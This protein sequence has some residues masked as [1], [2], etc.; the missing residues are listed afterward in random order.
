MYF[1]SYITRI[2]YNAAL[3]K[4]IV[5]LNV[6][7][8]TASI[9]VTGCFITYGIGQILSGLIGDKYKPNYVILAGI[10]GSSVINFAMVFMPNIALINAVWCIN[11]FFQALF[12]PPLVRIMTEYIPEEKY[13]VSVLRVSQS[14]YFAT[15]L[16]YALVP[17]IITFASWRFVFVFSS[18]S[19]FLFAALWYFCTKDMTF[20]ATAKSSQPQNETKLDIKFLLAVGFI[21]MFL[22]IILQGMLREGVSTWMPTYV[23]EVFNLGSSVSILTGVILPVF[24]IIGASV[25]NKIGEKINNE[26]KSATLFFTVAFSFNVILAVFF[27]KFAVLDVVSMAVIN[28]CMHGINIMLICDAPRHFAKYGKVSTVSGLYNC[29]TYIG[30]ALSIYGFAFISDKYGWNVTVIFWSVISLI[31]AVICASTIKTWRR[32][33]NNG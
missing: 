7:K 8:Q 15:M 16:I 4:I 13:A 12:W 18:V 5:D 11:G 28:T 2:N 24:N 31:G 32:F 23:A 33:R 22:A 29:S 17:V 9:A 26:L 19:G 14:A 30:A 25:M 10:I 1:V 27:S 20:A 6:T 3:T 21:P